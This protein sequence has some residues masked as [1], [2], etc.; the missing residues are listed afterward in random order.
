MDTT[1]MDRPKEIVSRIFAVS[2]ALGI[3]LAAGAATAASAVAVTTAPHIATQAKVT[4]S[5]P[6]DGHG[7]GYV[8]GCFGSIL[9]CLS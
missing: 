7:H 2:A 9:I 5:A 4:Q 1:Q 3:A 8:S 6:A